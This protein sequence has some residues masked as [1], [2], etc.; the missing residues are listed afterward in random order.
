MTEAAPLEAVGTVIVRDG[1]ILYASPL[2]AA[3]TERTSAALVGTD[4]FELIAPEDRARTAERYARRL[5]G[6]PTPLEYEVAL[7]LPAGERRAI[8]LRVDV[9][10]PD[11]VV[12]IRDVSARADRRPRLEAIA[13]LGVAIQRERS[14]AA[15]FERVRDGLRAIGLT[16]L[17][18]RRRWRAS[19][20]S[21]RRR[22]RRWPTRSTRR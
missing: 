17:L 4:P 7:A 18:L 19:A 10:G 11:V 6:E 13:A 8:E 2:V 16:S 22:R 9:D 5:R 21:G 12:R 20:S 1:K 15:V 14:E 3:L